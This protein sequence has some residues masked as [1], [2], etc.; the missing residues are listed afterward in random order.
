MTI[1]PSWKRVVIKWIILHLKAIIGHIAFLIGF[2]R[3]VSI[4]YKRNK[5]DSVYIEW[6][7]KRIK[8]GKEW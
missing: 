2:A 8:W 4:Y 6:T 7:R 5:I 1:K 3:E